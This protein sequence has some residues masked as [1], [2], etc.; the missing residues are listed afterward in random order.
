LQDL[1]DRRHGTGVND[2]RRHRTHGRRRRRPAATTTTGPTQAIPAAPIIAAIAITDAGN[3][4][5]ATEAATEQAHDRQESVQPTHDLSPSY[6]D[7]PHRS[8]RGASVSRR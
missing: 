8:W 1:R 6:D 4:V 5:M 3:M 2:G 7:G